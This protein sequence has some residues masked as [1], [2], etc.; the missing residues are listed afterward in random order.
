M[1]PA[2]PSAGPW[3]G[4]WRLGRATFKGRGSRG[5]Q[6]GMGPAPPPSRGVTV[7]RVALCD[8]PSGGAV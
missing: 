4:V 3:G 2:A 7:H 1:A 8:S 5:V 6:G